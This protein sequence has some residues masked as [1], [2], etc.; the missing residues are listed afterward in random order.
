MNCKKFFICLVY[1]F[2]FFALV[3][4][5]S[6]LPWLREIEE[7]NGYKT[8]LELTEDDARYMV[9]TW[10]LTIFGFGW[11]GL[12]ELRLVIVTKIA[13][14]EATKLHTDKKRT[15]TENCCTSV[16][17]PLESIEIALDIKYMR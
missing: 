12:N 4:C 15:A 17:I 5:A 16:L 2:W 10:W 11:I 14:G 1:I 7:S 6:F 9:V 8:Y 13:T 3:L